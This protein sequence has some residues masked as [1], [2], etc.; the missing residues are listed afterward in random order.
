LLCDVIVRFLLRGVKDL[1]ALESAPAISYLPVRREDEGPSPI[2]PAQKAGSC[3][4]RRRAAL[5]HFTIAF[6]HKI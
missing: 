4:L 1:F 6:D 3:V 5:G 2:L